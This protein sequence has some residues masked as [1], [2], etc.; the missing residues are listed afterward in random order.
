M[1]VLTSSGM[2]GGQ[3]AGDPLGKQPA[4]EPSIVEGK[5][6]ASVCVAACNVQCGTWP[7]TEFD[8]CVVSEPITHSLLYAQQTHIQQMC[9]TPSFSLHNAYDDRFEIV[10]NGLST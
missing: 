2:P 9:A 8:L 7:P 1:I 10:I 5:V 4:I 6:M 3:P